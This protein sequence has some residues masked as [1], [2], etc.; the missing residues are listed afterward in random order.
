VIGSDCSEF[1]GI[2]WFEWV[3]E[4]KQGC[5][6]RISAIMSITQ[7][8]TKWDVSTQSSVIMISV[9]HKI[10][11]ISGHQHMAANNLVRLV[12]YGL[13]L[14]LTLRETPQPAPTQI[15]STNAYQNGIELESR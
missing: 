10:T 8:N 12:G 3:P 11:Q 1:Q 13:V 4:V 14:W 7:N 6:L 2:K 5:E 15:K 9:Q